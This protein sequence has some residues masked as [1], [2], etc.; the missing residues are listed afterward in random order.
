MDFNNCRLFKNMKITME[1]KVAIV[2]S[3][4]ENLLHRGYSILRKNGYFQRL[5]PQ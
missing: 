5:Y 3:A 1:A 4:G 2:T